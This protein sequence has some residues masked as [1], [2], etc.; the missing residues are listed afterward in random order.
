MG[1]AWNPL[2]NLKGVRLGFPVVA[3]DVPQL[4]MLAGLAHDVPMLAGLQLNLAL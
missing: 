1:P 2:I 3:Q 4:P